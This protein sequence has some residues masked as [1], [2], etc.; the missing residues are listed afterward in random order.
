MSRHLVLGNGQLLVTFDDRL[1]L[2][3]FYYPHVGL[4]NHVGGFKNRMGVWA[5]GH[6]S[7]VE[8][9]AWRLQIGYREASLV[10]ACT[11]RHE[12]LG[13]VLDVSDAVHH[14]ENVYLKRVTVRNLGPEARDIRLFFTQ[15]F[16]ID[17]TNVGDTAVYDPAAHVVY[18]YKRNRYFLV[19]GASAQGPIYQFATGTK[20]FQGAEG[21]WRDAEDGCLAGNPIAQGSVDSAVSFRLYLEPGAEED[22]WYWITAARNYSEALYLNSFVLARTPQALLQQT[23]TYWRHWLN[24]GRADLVD[25][26]DDLARLYR[27]SLLMVRAHVD[28]GGAIIAA[29]DG[30]ILHQQRDHYSYMWPRDG[31]LAAY[32]LCRAGFP[33]ATKTFFLFCADALTSDGYLLHKYNPDG[34]VGSSWHPWYLDGREQLPIQEDETGLVLF[35]LWEYYRQSGDIELVYAL[36]PTLVER[37][38]DFLCNY[39]HSH[40][41]L[42]QESYDLW[43][44]RRGIFTFTVAAVYGGL[45]GAA[46]LMELQGDGE[47]TARYRQMA[48]RI[49]HG[50]EEHLYEASLG[51]FIRGIYIRPDGTVEKDMTLESSLY[52]LVEFGLFPATDPRVVRTMEAIEEG[53]RVRTPVGG[54]ARYSGDCYFRS[55]WDMA[56]VPGN[57]WFITSLWLAEWRAQVATSARDLEGARQTLEWVQS[58]AL[59]SGLLSEQLDPV[60]GDPVSVAPLTWSHAAYVL[61]VQRYVEAYRRLNACELN[62]AGLELPG[63]YGE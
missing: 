56:A 13:I 40:L 58:Y 24:K 53:L 9:E 25:L 32:A 60:T 38:A 6:F 28:R 27:T 30:E 43:E 22:V 39:I 59:S 29:A 31:A 21:T 50:V 15:D 19:N 35:A 17:E 48:E 42:P 11:A 10:S 62:L 4:W 44:E 20:R 5:A 7:W 61:A 63:R 37:A 18:H 54:I 47:R 16:S 1:N 12:A 34:S 51:R 46:H 45:L 41:N 8:E 23:E 36:T 3:D 33:E 55:Y 14:R 49:R 26:S 57:P 52:G 2:R